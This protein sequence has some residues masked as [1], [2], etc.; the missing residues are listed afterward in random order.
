MVKYNDDAKHIHRLAPCPVYDIAGMEAWLEDMAKEGHLLSRDG[1]FMGFADFEV[2]KPVTMKYRLQAAP[3][4]KSAFEE[5]EPDDEEMELSEAMGWEY[6]ARRGE[7]HIY[8]SSDPAAREL[9]TDPLVQALAIKTVNKRM[10]N[11][12]VS[13][14]LWLV[15]YPIFF[16]D[17]GIVRATIATGSLFAIYSLAMLIWICC[18]DL[19]AIFRL[20]ALRKRL[21]SGEGID[22]TRP[23]KKYALRHISAR[24]LFVIAVIVWAVLTI[25][26]FVR[27]SDVDRP[28]GE[29]GGEPPFATMADFYPDAIE[30]VPDN[31]MGLTNYFEYIS[32]PLISPISLIWRESAQLTLPDGS[33]KDGNLTV[34]YHEMSCPLLAEIVAWEFKRDAKN[35]RHFEELSLPEL[36]IDHA[37]A[38]TDIFTTVLLREGS[39]VLVA[40]YMQYDEAP[41]SLEQWAQTLADSIK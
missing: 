31:F 40:S 10:P 8:R 7:F 2:S 17:E 36:G 12:I 6:V 24:L 11:H 29:Y 34:Y 22:R 26:T 21:E 27:A 32:D 4:A 33:I 1:F 18:R 16:F 14:V 9:N 19:R 38:Y 13:M 3:K 39:T 20:R 23:W 37:E 35:S 15:I 28:L 5:G 25:F 30:Y 41:L